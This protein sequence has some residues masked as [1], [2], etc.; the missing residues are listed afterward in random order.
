MSNVIAGVI[1]GQYGY[2]EE[3][4]EAKKQIWNRCKEGFQDLP[5]AMNPI[6]EGSKP[7]YWLSCLLIDENAMCKQVRNGSSALYQP[8]HVNSCPT[9]ILEWFSKYNAEGRPIWKPMHMQ[10]MYRDY[11]GN[12]VYITP[13]ERLAVRSGEVLKTRITQ[14]E[15]MISEM[16]VL[17]KDFKPCGQITVQLIREEGT[18]DDYYIEIK[19]VNSKAISNMPAFDSNDE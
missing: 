12:P 13:R 11:D 14:D 5:V 15:T 6:M 17:V 4:I 7:N 18:G 9:E 3:H 16:Q 10:P 2:L 8:E 1:R 19:K